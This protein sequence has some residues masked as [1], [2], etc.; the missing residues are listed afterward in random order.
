ME[1]S[2]DR[3]VAEVKGV[4]MVRLVVMVAGLMFSVTGWGAE[5]TRINEVRQGELLLKTG[6]PNQYRLAPVISTD[7]V[8]EITGPIARTRVRQQ[9][10]NPGEQWM[11]GVYAFPLPE[12]AAV[13]H[14]RMVVGERIIEG[15]IQER[16]QAK[17]SY[18]KAKSEGRRASLVEQIR[19]DLF[20][21]SVA[22]IGPNS[23]ITIELEYQELLE[24]RDGQFS[25]RYPMAITPRY[26]PDAVDDS[27]I[28]ELFEVN[29]GWT[30]VPLA[31][32]DEKSGKKTGGSSG[33]SPSAG[34]KNP[35]V[36]LTVHLN[37][38]FPLEELFSRYH[39]V[40]IESPLNG[41]DG[42]RRIRLDA[43]T[44]NG[45]QDFVLYWRPRAGSAPRAAFFTEKG[46]GADQHALLMVM[47]PQ[48]K[49]VVLPPPRELIYVIDTSGSMSGPP[50]AQAREALRK[51]VS[52][53]TPRDSFNI[54]EFNDGASSLFDGAEQA[55]PNRLMVA[56]HYITRLEAKGGTEIMG[57]L[58]MALAPR[59]GEE[60]RS[61][62]E[63][64]QQVVFITDGAVGNEVELFRYI[65]ENL[66][67]RRL[68]TVGIGSAPNSYFMRK[69][70]QFGKGTFTYI[71]DTDEVSE[72]ME[73]L[74]TRMEQAV[75]TDLVVELEGVEGEVVQMLPEQL[76]DLYR[77]EPV[78]ISMKMRQIPTR[79]V[80]RGRFNAQPWESEIALKG[81]REQAGLGTLF[82]RR[83][84]ES[85]MDRKAVGADEDEVRDAIIQLGLRYH[86]V[87][88][89]TSLVA[90]DVTPAEKLQGIEKDE[91]KSGRSLSS[92]R[93]AKTATDSGIRMVGGALL[94][95]LSML[96]YR[97]RVVAA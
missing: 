73:L 29:G 46:S 17:K 11:E 58:R 31:N 83:M 19:P 26:L 6:N 25:V 45:K 65:H 93:L 32:V 50:L 86:L 42:E 34:G 23:T 27:E 77:G 91:M 66:D 2:M 7:A 21:T 28:S 55:T 78:V 80:L 75:L 57:A 44:H 1:Q 72:K 43:S 16:Q 59:Y 62:G 5:I 36:S 67:R 12:S 40:S 47:P 74:F 81:G 35:P 82:G 85:W 8:I 39:K 4:W 54:I 3:C 92:L 64:L 14:M 52:R 60:G 76:P 63:M 24:W 49:A 9:F 37:A 22:N 15:V 61:S 71:G 41:G 56:D 90:V 20:T 18:Q 69:S 51:A 87:S 94:L 95:I 10:T 38:G 30:V 79:A 48:Q 97:R 88:K 53:L 70:A 13:D 68:F 33:E 96:L 84:I 89:Y